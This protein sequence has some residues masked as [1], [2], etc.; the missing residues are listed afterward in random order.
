MLKEVLRNLSFIGLRFPVDYTRRLDSKYLSRNEFIVQIRAKNFSF[1]S[2]F[3]IEKWLLRWVKDK[4]SWV[5]LFIICIIKY[6]GEFVGLECLY[7]DLLGCD[8]IGNLCV[9]VFVYLIVRKDQATVC[10]ILKV[11]IIIREDP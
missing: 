6:L 8:T 5:F 3:R 10:D 1:H 7:G 11:I 9:V 4:F 2:P